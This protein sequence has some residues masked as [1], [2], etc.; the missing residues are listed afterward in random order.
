MTNRTEHA[1]QTDI[2][3]HLRLRGVYCIRVN[4]GAFKVRNGK[5]YFRATDRVGVSDILAFPGD[6]R[7]VCLEVKAA[8]GRQTDNQR[9][10]QA[11]MD[12]V[13]VPYHIVRSVDEALQ[14]VGEVA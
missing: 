7:V 1:I 14:A 13:G 3:Y 5:G 9:A 2:L 8:K 12:S 10:F 6:G 11:D 4:Q